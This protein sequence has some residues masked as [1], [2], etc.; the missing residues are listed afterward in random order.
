MSNLEELSLYFFNHYDP[1]I[2]GDDLKKNIINHLTRLNK[3]TFYIHSMVALSRLVNLPSNEDIEN[4]FKNFPSNQ[5]ISSVDYFSK[6]NELRCH[7]Y[8]HPYTWP[9]YF[10]ITSN[11]RGELFKYVRII[12]LVDERPFEHEFFLRIQK[13]FP[14]IEQLYLRNEEPQKNDNQQWPIIQYSHLTGLSLIDTHENYVEQFLINTKTCLL[15][16]VYLHVPYDT[17]RR[18]THDFTRDATRVNYSKIIVL[19]LQN[20]SELTFALKDY[21]PHAKI[22]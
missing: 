13:S 5:I 14:F 8:T 22:Y 7:I 18:V 10:D 2:D 15:N 11:F 9:S 16:N 19:F 12:S 17:L 4:T 3:F 6:E 20:R 21:F 1:I